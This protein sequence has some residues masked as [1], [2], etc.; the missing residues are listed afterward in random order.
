M[1]PVIQYDTLISILVFVK[2]FI[3]KA[4]SQFKKVLIMH[5]NRHSVQI[6]HRKI[7]IRNPAYTQ[8]NGIYAILSLCF[9]AQQCGK[10][11]IP[12]LRNTPIC[13]CCAV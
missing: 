12:H 8:K 13:V 6:L 2:F 10:N 1:I 5:K 4:K 11:W 7:V 3:V 9:T